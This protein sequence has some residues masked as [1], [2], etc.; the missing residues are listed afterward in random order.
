M[1]NT[2]RPVLEYKKSDQTAHIYLYNQIG[3]HRDD[4]RDSWDDITDIPTLI[5]SLD[6]YRSQGCKSWAYH[7]NCEG[8]EVAQGQ[9][10]IA[11]HAQH[12][13]DKVTW[14]VEGI[15][16]SMGAV[17]MLP[18]THTVKSWRHAMFMYHR[19][20]GGMYGDSEELRNYASMLDKFESGIVD[21]MA[22]RMKCDA[23]VV[24]QKFMDGKDHWITAAEA[25]ELGLIDEIFDTPD[26]NF[27]ETEPKAIYNYCL[28]KFNNNFKPNSTKMEKKLSEVLNI[29][30][31]APE[32]ARVAAVE[33]IIRDRNE[34][35]T[36]VTNLTQANQT[37]ET[38]VT[39]AHEAKISAVINQAIGDKKITEEDRPT[40]TELAKK[41][42]DNTVKVIN[43]LPSVGRVVNQLGNETP[44]AEK[45][46][47]FEDYHRAG[48]LENLKATNRARYDQLY[49][50][51]FGKQHKA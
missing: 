12:P 14:I 49:T 25:K 47:K 28:N 10:F 3:Q 11:Y 19:V 31:D 1:M 26:K 30:E 16:A 18:P 9:A 6:Q 4:N 17:M 23:E 35:Q 24:R 20:K 45:N 41:D 51:K 8:G 42:F 48:K 7:V 13:K 46:W 5:S 44:E 2:K 43:K 32:E 34:A 40:Y 38:Q 21:M 33:A 36:K 29:A 22:K 39:A 50:E 15:A 27:K 37:L